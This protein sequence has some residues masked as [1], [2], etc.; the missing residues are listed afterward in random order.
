MVTERCHTIQHIWMSY[1]LG[2]VGKT[3]FTDTNNPPPNNNVLSH[4]F[5]EEVLA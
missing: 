1:L 2:F 5:G 4:A 3:G